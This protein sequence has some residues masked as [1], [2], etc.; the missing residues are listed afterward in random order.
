MRAA[1]WLCGAGLA[2]LLAGGCA[3]SSSRLAS[4]AMREGDYER[5]MSFLTVLAIEKPTNAKIRARLG[6]A[7]YRSGLIVE[8]EKS[9]GDAL[10]LDPRLAAAHLYLGYI[11][12]GDGKVEEALRR[13]QLYLDIK[14]GHGPAAA[15]VAMRIE[16]LRRHRAQTFAQEQ[17]AR[18]NEL[19]P[20]R[21]SDSTIGVVYFNSLLLSESLRPLA[22]GL[23]E[24]L[25]TDFS[26]VPGLRVVERLQTQKLLEELEI[27]QT[28]AFDSSSAPRLG[29]LLGAAHVLGG[30]ASELTHG[31]LLIDPQLVSTKTGNVQITEEQSGELSQLFRMQ[32]RI[33]VDVSDRLGFKLSEADRD[34]I[35]ALPTESFVAFLAYA[36]GLD[37]QDRG[38][39][40]DALREF[41]RAADLDPHFAAAKQSAQNAKLL[42]AAAAGGESG[43]LDQFRESTSEN[44]EWTEQFTDPRDRLSTQSRNT[45]FIPEV[46]TASRGD[47]P[48]TPPPA[49]TS[50]IIRGHFDDRP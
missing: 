1:L 12:E 43:S 38:L 21:Y 33:V 42:S 32:K 3:S 28:A 10:T 7:Q 5:A 11:A 8:A 18:E 22:K 39:Y 31:R 23:A 15:D 40:G 50:V 4:T 2:I 49:P 35:D 14:S 44:T 26:K 34:S 19:K 16:T 13:Y 48:R 47:Q 36:R 30:D 41:E 29:K 20:G 45:G 9:F 25:V 46:G 17:I 6:E 37:L 27:S 24:M